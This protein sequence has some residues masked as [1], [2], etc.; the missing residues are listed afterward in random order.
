MRTELQL[1]RKQQNI[2]Y[3]QWELWNKT[4]N[5]N[6]NIFVEYYEQRGTRVLTFLQENENGRWKIS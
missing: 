3:W 6:E 4:W 1:F 2:N 5:L